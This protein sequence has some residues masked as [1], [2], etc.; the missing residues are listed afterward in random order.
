VCDLRPVGADL[1][2]IRPG[3]RVHSSN[4]ASENPE[5]LL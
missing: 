1:F 5:S 2:L 3:V 4:L